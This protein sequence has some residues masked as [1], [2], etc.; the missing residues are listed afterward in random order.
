MRTQFTLK[1]AQSSEQKAHSQHCFSLFV[2]YKISVDGKSAIEDLRKKLFLF[3]F[4]TFFS[5]FIF[6]RDDI[7][8]WR[9][10]IGA[11]PG[12]M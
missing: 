9:V 5:S 8:V 12:V 4:L 3:V 7:Q 11:S 1:R 10:R 6:F 2:L